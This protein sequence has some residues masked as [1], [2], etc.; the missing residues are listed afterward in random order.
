MLPLALDD[1]LR[2]FKLPGEPA[3]GDLPTELGDT[4]A[5]AT[6]PTGVNNAQ[7]AQSC[8]GFRCVRVRNL[9][10][11]SHPV[12]GRSRSRLR[13]VDHGQ[14]HHQTKREIGEPG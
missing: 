9:D 2:T 14:T 7:Y 4:Q 10:V 8:H 6:P 1:F 3:D 12:G 11:F 5:A 13:G